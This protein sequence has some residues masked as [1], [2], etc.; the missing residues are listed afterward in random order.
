M[1]P[2]DDVRMAQVPDLGRIAELEAGR[3]E[4]RAH[5]AVGEDGRVAR[6]AARASGRWPARPPRAAARRASGDGS[7]GRPAGRPV[8]RGATVRRGRSH[9]PTIPGPASAPL[10]SPA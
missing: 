6:R 3:E 9:R 1:D 4:H 8:G 10:T 5:R 7:R 2:P